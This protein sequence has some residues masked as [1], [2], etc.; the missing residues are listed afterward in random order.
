M[1]RDQSTHQGYRIDEHYSTRPSIWILS[2]IGTIN[3]S[4]LAWMPRE[5]EKRSLFRIGV[6]ETYS[7]RI[8]LLWK[9]SLTF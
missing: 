3:K 8:D 2:T 9:A 5:T 7:P 6:V 4:R 1:K